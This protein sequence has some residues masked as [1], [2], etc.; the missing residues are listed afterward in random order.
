MS[1]T[2]VLLVPALGA[3]GLALTK[4]S[5][6]KACRAAAFF[7][8][9]AAFA[10]SVP[11]AFRF[12]PS[13]AGL[14]FLEERDWIPAL[15]IRYIVGLDGISLF[16]FLLTAFLCPLAIL[17]AFGSID[18]REREFYACMLLLESGLL[19]TFA[20]ADLFLFYVVW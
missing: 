12:D 6:A 10:L 19:G 7:V 17:G 16:L 11:L 2:A 1:I 8:S 5:D 20:A 9:L 4:P 14:Q 15:G 13:V 3:L 18:R